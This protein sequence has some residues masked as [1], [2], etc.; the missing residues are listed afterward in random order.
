MVGCSELEH[1]S[2]LQIVYL[3]KHSLQKAKNSCERHQLCVWVCVAIHH[4]EQHVMHACVRA[5][6]HLVESR[7]LELIVAV[8]RAPVSRLACR[9]GLQERLAELIVCRV[10][11]PGRLLQHSHELPVRKETLHSLCNDWGVEVVWSS[12]EESIV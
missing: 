5:A 12:C 6:T 11:A 9:A 10:H 1:T 2:I 4:E 7:Q 8:H 3:L